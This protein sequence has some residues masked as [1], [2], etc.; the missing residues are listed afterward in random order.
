MKKMEEDKQ[1]K[2]LG[3]GGEEPEKN[4]SAPLMTSCSANTISLYFLPALFSP[5]TYFEPG[6]HLWTIFMYICQMYNTYF[7]LCKAY[8]WSFKLYNP[9]DLFYI[10]I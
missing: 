1:K 3:G 5:P 9:L 4:I 6:G 2:K 10:Y 8:G 7:P